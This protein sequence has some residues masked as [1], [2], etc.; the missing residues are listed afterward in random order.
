MDKSSIP[1]LELT[2]GKGANKQTIQIY[3]WLTQEA[4]NEY[5]S[6][7]GGDSGIDSKQSLNDIGQENVD[8]FTIKASLKNVYASQQFLLKSMLVK[9]TYE[10]FN[11][12]RPSIR[13]EIVTRVEKIHNKKK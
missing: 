12:M 4:E 8:E 9:P 5:L 7:L 3:K 11:V 6:I 1:T 2:I 10:E 13:E